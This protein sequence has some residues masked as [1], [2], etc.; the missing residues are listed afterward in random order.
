MTNPPNPIHTHPDGPPEGVPLREYV[1][2]RLARLASDSSDRTGVL[3]EL[4]DREIENLLRLVTQQFDAK[5][6]AVA[7]A[8]TAQKEAVEKAFTAQTAL[9]DQ[10]FG[11]QSDAVEKALTAQKEAVS[12]ALAAV[13]RESKTHAQAHEREHQSQ[14]IA[15]D[16]AEK[17]TDERFEEANNFRSQ[18]ES[19]RATYAR[20]DMLN[21][22][23]RNARTVVEKLDADVRVRMEKLEADSR[24]RLEKL[25]SDLRQRI[26][27][28]SKARGDALLPL[29]AWMQ[30]SGGQTAVWIAIGGVALAVVIFLANWATAR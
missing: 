1:E 12:T 24:S 18:I 22:I 30:R 27:V 17:R 16:K 23:E 8:L 6:E 11:A 5:D 9:T 10:R 20:I 26:E 13:E 2:G 29:T 25:E 21:V 7:A 15:I 28:E 14:A 19:E 3:R 4:Y